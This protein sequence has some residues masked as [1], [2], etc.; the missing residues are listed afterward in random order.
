M[1]AKNWLKRNDSKKSVLDLVRDTSP[2]GKAAGKLQRYRVGATRY[3]IPEK[4]YCDSPVF[5]ERYEKGE[6]SDRPGI[7][8]EMYAPCR[9][10]DKC[11]LFRALSWRERMDV[12]IQRFHDLGLRTW[13]VTLTF[14]PMH[15][16]GVIMEAQRAMER[17]GREPA[18]E[19]ASYRHVK[20]WLKRLRKLNAQFRFVAVPEYGE[21]RGRLHWHLLMHEV[22]PGSLTK[23]LLD[24][25][26]RSFTKV[27]VV[28]AGVFDKK[29]PRAAEKVYSG[30]AVCRYLTK[31]LTKSSGRISASIS[32]GNP[33]YKLKRQDDSLTSP[34]PSL[35][36]PKGG[37]VRGLAPV[38]EAQTQGRGN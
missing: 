29:A 14:S 20:L 22:V 35:P 10:C 4:P 23:R 27:R 38:G 37:R 16:A 9:R 17:K 1:S 13:F 5:V 31:Y 32:Y 30:Q 18:I 25:Q 24:S 11:R 3:V 2:L 8:L 26:W 7:S 21:A 6:G 19:A 33:T 15:L 34:F 36:R 12:E 28:K